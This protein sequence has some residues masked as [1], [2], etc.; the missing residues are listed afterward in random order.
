MPNVSYGDRTIFYS[1]KDNPDSKSHYISVSRD[2]GV[3]LKGPRLSIP[4]ADQLVL[5]KARWILDKL[6]IVRTIDAEAIVTG[7]RIAYLGKHYYTEVII[8]PSLAKAQIDFNHSRFRIQVNPATD[9][10]PAIQQ[11]LDTFFRTR[12]Q[13]KLTARVRQWAIKT[14]LPYQALKFR[15]MS[16]RW[17]SC[18]NTNTII[19]NPEVVKL[20]Y[21]LI[22]Y[23]IV[24]E[25]CHT[26][27]KSHSKEFWAEVSRHLVN[28]KELDDR[29]NRYKL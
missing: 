24:H 27:V 7:S 21:T 22:D 4:Q 29:I 26:K 17:G 20:P 18:T 9:S 15:Q 10:Q 19:L 13:E 1:L 5:K 2:E 12:A 11:A 16:K 3:V 6:E 23:V 28:W 25:L 8:N 14:D